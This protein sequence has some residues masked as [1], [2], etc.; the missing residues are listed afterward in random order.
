MSCKEYEKYQ[1]GKVD[2]EEFRQHLEVCE[3]CRE[4]EW[5]DSLLMS[6][7]R[8]LK[9]PVSAPGLW[10]R[11]ETSMREENLAKVKPVFFGGFNRRFNLLLAA[12]AL[13][14]AVA[15][16]IY[17]GVYL[18]RNGSGLLTDSALERIEQTEQAYMRAIDQLE[19]QALPSLEKMDIELM[20]LYKDRLA[21]IDFQI[22]QCKEALMENP[23]NSH[24]RRYMLAALQD[25]KETLNEI[26]RPQE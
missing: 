19:E 6:A 15:V 14:V 25:K 26:L 18:E 5:R 20:L 24:I 17:F 23:A 3:H 11:I 8:S 21:V 2:A 9:E 7:A 10:E 16:G 13:L 4:L 1:L 12:A 22:R